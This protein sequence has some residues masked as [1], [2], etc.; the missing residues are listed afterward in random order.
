MDKIFK[1]LVF[2]KEAIED[3]ATHI[4]KNV[5]MQDEDD[6]N[7]YCT[8]NKFIIDADASDVWA[9]EVTCFVGD[10]RVYTGTV[11]VPTIVPSA[12]MIGTYLAAYIIGVDDT[13]NDLA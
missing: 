2:M 7:T 1:D 13:N 8:I 6:E 3:E 5:Y 4:I 10:R 9:I 11:Y 12:R